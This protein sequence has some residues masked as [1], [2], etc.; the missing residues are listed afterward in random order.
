MVTWKSIV[1][2]LPVSKEIMLLLVQEFL[3]TSFHS[4]FCKPFSY[5]INYFLCYLKNCCKHW[6]RYFVVTRLDLFFP[7]LACRIPKTMFISFLWYIFLA[8]FYLFFGVLSLDWYWYCK[9]VE[10]G[11]DWLYMLTAIATSILFCSRVTENITLNCKFAYLFGLLTS[12]LLRMYNFVQ[13]I[14]LITY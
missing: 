7:T 5:K 10:K 13:C 6:I 1:L 4:S 9:I 11:F 14:S 8:D 3:W 2:D 12:L